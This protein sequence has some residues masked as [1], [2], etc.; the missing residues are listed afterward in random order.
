MRSVP[1]P[2]RPCASEA[3]AHKPMHLFVS[4][5][6]DPLR[7]IA[8]DCRRAFPSQRL[9]TRWI[10]PALNG[11]AGGRGSRTP[12]FVAT[13]RQEQNLTRMTSPMIAKNGSLSEG[14]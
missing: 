13:H 11:S 7:L 4:I 14:Y 5:R 9:G 3:A 10:S 6:D 12:P 1:E 2:A 8:F